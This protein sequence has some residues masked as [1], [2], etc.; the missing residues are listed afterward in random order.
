LGLPECLDLLTK[1]VQL[2]FRQVEHTMARHAT[3]V[4]GADNLGKLA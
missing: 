1:R 4:T 2:F 3:L